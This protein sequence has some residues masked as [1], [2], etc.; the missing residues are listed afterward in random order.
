[1]QQ[2]NTISS[3]FHITM[4]LVQQIRAARA[5]LDWSQSE[6]A[7]AASL[8]VATI[9]RMEAK[10][11]LVRGS[12]DSVWKIQKALETAGITFV[13]ADDKGGPGVR[14]KENPEG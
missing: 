11:G 8:G 10:E 1:M 12:A 6:L 9:R 2:K 5:L 4:I 13:P 14:L 3:I 7:K